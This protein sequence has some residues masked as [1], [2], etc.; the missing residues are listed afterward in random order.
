MYYKILKVMLHLCIVFLCALYILKL[1]IPEQFV[2]TIENPTLVLIGNYIDTHCW[3]EYLTGCITAFITYWLYL[4]AVC[5]QW[6]LKFTEC[7]IILIIIVL[8][9]VCSI[10]DVNLYTALSYTSF[11]FLPALF[12]ADIKNIAVVYTA[13]IFSQFLTLSIRDITAYVNAQNTLILLLL[14]LECYFWLILFYFYYNLKKE[15]QLWVGNVRQSTENLLAESKIKLKNST[16]KLSLYKRIRNFMKNNFNKIALQ[17]HFRRFRLTLKDFLIDELWIYLIII[18]SIA[19]C[20]WIFNC[21][22]EGILLCIA[23]TCIRRAFNKQYH[24]NTTA[25]CISLTLGLIWFAIPLTWPVTVSLLSSIPIAFLICFFGFLAQDRLD[26]QKTVRSLQT[27][28]SQLFL[29]ISKN[30]SIKDIYAM[31]K[32]ELYAHCRSKGL[33]DNDCKIA[34]Y[35]IIERLKGKELYDAIGYSE[36]QTIRKRKTILAKIK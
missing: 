18:G 31:S 13:H 2:I 6:Y 8:S 24:C 5:Q 27:Y 7:I 4:C 34:Y 21:W 12:K 9:L 11:I 30:T 10:I 22:I 16:E 29:Q 15:K 23:H 14:T 17:N 26:L 20:S 25:L 19:L 35:I 3:L 28:T 1:V 36:R 33:D 32:E